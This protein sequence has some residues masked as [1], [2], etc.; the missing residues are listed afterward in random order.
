MSRRPT[1]GER[2]STWEEDRDYK[3]WKRRFEKALD[4]KDYELI[5]ELL[6][7]AYLES[8]PKPSINEN[9]PKL[10]EIVKKYF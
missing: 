7:E 10:T 4:T 1:Y 9:D 6:Q 8:Y 5:E 2:M 3:V